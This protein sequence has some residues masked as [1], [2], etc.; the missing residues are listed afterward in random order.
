M[1]FNNNDNVIPRGTLGHDKLFKIRPF[2]D[3]LQ[4]R[5]NKIP[6][7]EHVAA[8]EQIIST[9]ARSTIK[10][11]NPKKPHK[12][13][14]K[15]IVLCGIS[16]FNY[17]FDIFAG[18]QSNVVPVDAPDLGKSSNVVLNLLHRVPK[19]VNHKIFFDNWFASIPLAVYLTKTKSN[20][21]LQKA[22]GKGV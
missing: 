16:G 21:R 17:S 18:A 7:E 5:L 6:I 10:Q 19:H 12:W 8:D 9:K 13:G 4:E 20:S 3:S 2:L 11:Y 1:H 14:F 22:I 15:V